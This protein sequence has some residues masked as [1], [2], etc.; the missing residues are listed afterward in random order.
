MA[1]T[2]KNEYVIGSNND[3]SN[4]LLNIDLNRLGGDLTYLEND[5]GT[6]KVSVGSLIESQGSIYQVATAAETPTG[7][8]QDG[9]YLFFDDSV[10]GFVWSNTAGTYDPTRGGIYDGS[11]R[12]QC[13]FR[14]SSATTYDVLVTPV[15][16]SAVF[17]GDVNIDGNLDVGGASDI[18]GKLD[19][20]GSLTAPTLNT[21]QGNNELYAM[22]QN[23]RTT[24]NVTFNNVDIDGRLLIQND[25]ASVLSSFF[26]MSSGG[27]GTFYFIDVP[28]TTT[29]GE[30]YD[31]FR[32]FGSV[33]GMHWSIMG[34]FGTTDIYTADGTVPVSSGRIT[35][36][37]IDGN[38]VT[39]VD[40]NDTAQIGNSLKIFAVST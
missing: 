16:G 9:A 4:A 30:V 10:P 38:T 19:V 34:R 7:T 39:T 17:D 1:I 40:E 3:L 21:G 28:F 26:Q 20:G 31:A 18:G 37:D 12:R 13:R 29:E 15:T 11:D 25:T 22:D 24:D 27:T 2:Q 23:V 14:L 36:R 5:G 35:F 32:V 8:A 33:A 6:L